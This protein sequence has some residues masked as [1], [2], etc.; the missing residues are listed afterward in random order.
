MKNS[1]NQPEA[2]RPGAAPSAGVLYMVATPIGHLDDIS[3][4]AME[5]LR[6]VAIVAAEDT[7]RSR[8]LLAHIS[9]QPRELVSL[10]DFNESG[11]SQQLI[12]RLRQGDDVAVVS[13][14]GTP[15]ISDP[16]FEIVRL[17]Q[18][19]GI[20]VVPVPG[21]SAL[22]ALLSA[23]PV[24]VERFYFEGF[25]PARPGARRK[26]LQA[27]RAL[28]TA[29][30]FFESPKRLLDT[31]RDIADVYGADAPVV[32]GKELTKLHEHVAAGAVDTL[33]ERFAADSALQKGEFACIIGA[34][35]TSAASDAELERTLRVLADEL[36]PTQAARIG[37]R[38][39][40][41]GKSELYRRL[42]RLQADDQRTPSSDG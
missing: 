21:A 20:R 10:H 30:V 41:I 6:S 31:L 24:A 37:A 7:R 14:A 40:G 38:L 12:E 34:H 11:R 17:A 9:A 5:T 18:T 29:I 4:R 16:G 26:R 36:P 28:D 3:V 35:G 13:D 19:A 22:T 39:T 27:L 42:L 23:S 2:P 15:L 1:T 8:V 32:V 33:R 25:L